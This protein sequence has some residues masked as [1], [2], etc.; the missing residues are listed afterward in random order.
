MVVEEVA[1]TGGRLGFGGRSFAYGFSGLA[2]QAI[3]TT[4]AMETRCIGRPSLGGPS[5]RGTAKELRAVTVVTT[6]MRLM[7]KHLSSLF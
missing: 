7:Y 3:F 2:R 5:Y 4:D 1:E 6:I